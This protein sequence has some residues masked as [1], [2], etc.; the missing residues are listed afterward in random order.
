MLESP[1]ER[2][3]GPGRIAKRLGV[4]VLLVAV[5]LLLSLWRPFNT[6]IYL[7]TRQFFTVEH[8]PTCRFLEH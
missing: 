1:D 7:G 6:L 3:W 4:V 8:L 5:S 2:P